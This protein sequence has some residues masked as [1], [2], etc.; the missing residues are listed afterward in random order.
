MLDNIDP[1]LMMSE[2]PQLQ[3]RP[4]SMFG[5]NDLLS[6]KMSGRTVRRPDGPRV[7]RTD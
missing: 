5:N 3:L 6:T 7:R 4:Q 2:C 1:S